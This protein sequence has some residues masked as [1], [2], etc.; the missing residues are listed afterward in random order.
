MDFTFQT[1]LVDFIQHPDGDDEFPDEEFIMDSED[2][3]DLVL[4]DNTL[5]DVY[6]ESMGYDGVRAL[7]R[8]RSRL[9]T[10]APQAP[11]HDIISIIEAIGDGPF[12]EA[13]WL[14]GSCVECPF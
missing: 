12:E 9:R 5:C 13:F 3:E 14:R 10:L 1:L 4:M 7:Q 8:I 11:E 6:G 2:E